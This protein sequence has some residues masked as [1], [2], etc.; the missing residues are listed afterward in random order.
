MA[1]HQHEATKQNHAFCYRLYWLIV[2]YTAEDVEAA[3]KRQM[4]MGMG[5]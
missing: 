1:M 4:A 5:R 3:I 2:V